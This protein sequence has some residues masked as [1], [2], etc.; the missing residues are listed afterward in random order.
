[1]FSQVLSHN[2]VALLVVV[3][4][5]FRAS[6]LHGVGP[7]SSH[8]VLISYVTSCIHLDLLYKRISSPITPVIDSV[9]KFLA[10][11]RMLLLTLG[12]EKGLRPFRAPA[13]V[14]EPRRLSNEAQSKQSHEA[15]SDLTRCY[16][17]HAQKEKLHERLRSFPP[18]NYLDILLSPRSMCPS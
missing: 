2:H 7:P 8:V 17:T 11:W 1:V 6:T 18:L 14:V 9:W 13:W 10:R 3:Y 12:Y 16:I 15:Q 4:R 5:R